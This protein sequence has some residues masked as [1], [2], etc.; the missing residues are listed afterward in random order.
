MCEQKYNK[1]I[2]GAWERSQQ[3]ACVSLNNEL[4]RRTAGA[5]APLYE[6][7][8]VCVSAAVFRLG[9]LSVAVGARAMNIQ[10]CRKAQL[11]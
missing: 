8:T 4:P 10:L 5:Y 11:T 1:T 9:S 3:P 2:G 6:R 7:S